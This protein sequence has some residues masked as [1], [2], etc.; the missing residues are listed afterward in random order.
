MN[1]SYKAL[2]KRK[3]ALDLQVN[4]I[5][6]SYSD[7]AVDKFNLKI[8]FNIVKSMSSLGDRG[9]IT[10]TGL[11]LEDIGALSTCMM[12]I[13]ESKPPRNFVQL[14][15]GYDTDFGV[16]FKGGVFTVSSNLDTS[17]MSVTLNVMPGFD[18]S[19]KAVIE[20]NDK[21]ATLMSICTKAAKEL[22]AP[23]NFTGE[24]KNY[25]EFNFKGSVFQL[26]ENL[27]RTVSYSKRIY[28]S[29]DVLHVED[30]AIPGTEMISISSESGLIGTPQASLEG[31]NFKCLLMPSIKVGS[32]VQLISR[33]LPL[34][35]GVYKVISLTMQGSNRSTP[36][37]CN[38]F[39]K[40]I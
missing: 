17:D 10:V 32:M 13:G 6:K 39:A 14:M 28:Y 29:D 15:A 7:A 21:P 2:F 34:L 4:N 16:I 27:Q 40:R 3:C 8:D 38:V 12:N 33:K 5:I 22:N 23:L 9:S 37:F 1:F 11:P 18:I 19:Q 35:N 26:L 30:T 25:S 31:I 20:I 24:D 36:Y